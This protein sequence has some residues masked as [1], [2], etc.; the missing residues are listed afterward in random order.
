M[1]SSGRTRIEELN[2][3]IEALQTE[4][5]NDD[6][7]S[8]RVQIGIVTVGGP[9]GDA[10][11]MLDWTDAVNFSAFPIRADHSTPLGAGVSIALQMIEQGKQNMRAAGISYT[12]PWMMIISDG[13]PTDPDDV[14]NMAVRECKDAEMSKKVEVFCIGVEGANLAKLAQLSARPPLMLAGMKFKELFVWLSSSLSAASRSRP[15]DKL[16]LPPTDPF[17]H[18]SM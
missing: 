5:Q 7:A 1:T 8:V 11:I 2:K 13:D 9:A 4:L 17:R 15:G 6:T 3:G 14:W 18:V 12:R 16:T 10:D